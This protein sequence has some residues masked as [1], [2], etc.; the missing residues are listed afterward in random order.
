MSS[1]LREKLLIRVSNP[2]T[3]IGEAKG[4]KAQSRRHDLCEVMISIWDSH[5]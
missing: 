1:S 5:S 4:Q 2:Y 3:I